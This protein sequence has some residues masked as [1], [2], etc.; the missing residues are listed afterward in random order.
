MVHSAPCTLV[1]SKYTGCI[2]LIFIVM[3]LLWVWV[4]LFV[5]QMALCPKF[6]MMWLLWV[7]L[8]FINWTPLC[9][10]FTVTQLLQV[11]LLF[12][13]WMP[14]HSKFT[15]TQLLQVHLLFI[16]QMP[17]HPKFTVM[18]LLQVHLL[19]VDWTHPCAQV[20]CDVTT[21]SL[22]TLC[23]LNAPSSCTQICQ[24]LHH[25]FLLHLHRYCKYFSFNILL[26]C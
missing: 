5:D 19:F 17:L 18:W 24:R 21:S 11:H 23:Q 3:Q 1:N 6:T 9:S 2:G 15:M 16:N 25:S 20:Y 4:L 7:Y 26:K 22:P 12:V 10:Q 13:D 8:L 14:L